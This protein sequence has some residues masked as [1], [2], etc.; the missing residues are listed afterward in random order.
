MKKITPNASLGKSAML[1]NVLILGMFVISIVCL[2][3]FDKVNIKLIHETPGYEMAFSE[4]REVEKP[5]RQAQADVDYYAYKL[6]T[7]KQ[8]EISTDKKKAKEQIEEVE[9]TIHTLAAKEVELAHVDSVISVQTILFEAIQVPFDDLTKQA[10][11]KKTTFKVMLWI[12]ILFFVGKVLFF[13]SWTY[14]SLLNLRITSP[15]MTKSISPFWAYLGWF[16]PG[17]NF[18]KPYMV[19]AEIYNET[20]YILLDKNIIQEDK[21]TNSDFNLGLWWGLL[22]M[23]AL[24]MPYIISATFFNEGPMFYKLSHTGVAVTAI[25]FWVFYLV[26]ECVL[27][28]RGVKMNQI[29]FENHPKFDLQ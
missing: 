19:Y 10:Q 8:R 15:W 6:D 20:T 23:S 2:L 14:K 27:I 26:Q 25:I 3:N 13:A 29:L 24:V 4:L 21:D 16:I 28:L 12:M 7:L 11:S 22:I 5:R 1:V 9:R 17:Y 18:I